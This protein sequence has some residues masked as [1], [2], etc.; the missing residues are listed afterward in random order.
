MNRHRLQPNAQPDAFYMPTFCDKSFRYLLQ[1]HTKH[2]PHTYFRQTSFIELSSSSLPCLVQS[3]LFYFESNL[4]LLSLA[5]LLRLPTNGPRG[6]GL[7]HFYQWT[8]DP[9]SHLNEYFTYSRSFSGSVGLLLRIG[10][11]SGKPGIMAW[12]FTTQPGFSHPSTELIY[13]RRDLN[14]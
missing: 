8:K 7:A 9:K 10:N 14:H 11:T 13:C 6:C 2:R 3:F 4:L 5:E 1:W 12:H